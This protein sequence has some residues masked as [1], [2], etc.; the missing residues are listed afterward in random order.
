MIPALV[1]EETESGDE[2]A[3]LPAGD[4]EEQSLFSRTPKAVAKPVEIDA[5]VLRKNIEDITSQLEHVLEGQ[6]KRD[7]GFGLDSFTVG[8]AIEG[9]GKV[10][11]VAEV[12]VKASI[13]LTFKR[14]ES[15]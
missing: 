10:F 7:S 13:E 6:A 11:L 4:V 8:L 2:S 9:K 1:L 15:S 14:R 3:P 5:E 12:G